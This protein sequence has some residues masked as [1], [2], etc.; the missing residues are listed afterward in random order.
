VSGFISSEE[1]NS[2]L[3]LLIEEPTG[4]RRRFLPP[5]RAVFFEIRV[6]GG[7]LH[8]LFFYQKRN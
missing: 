4:Y 2:L 3:L 6:F 1:K 8:S 5:T 7:G